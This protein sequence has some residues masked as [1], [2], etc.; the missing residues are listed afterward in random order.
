[1]LAAN[2]C[3]FRHQ[4]SQN[5]AHVAPAQLGHLHQQDVVVLNQTPQHSV[6]RDPHVL[7]SCSDAQARYLDLNVQGAGKTSSC[8]ATSG[9]CQ[10]TREES[11]HE[12]VLGQRVENTKIFGRLGGS[13]VSIYLRLTA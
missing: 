5:Q 8:P 13:A 9:C 2:S 11:R 7:P 12:T 6:W 10:E 3:L 1:M 4:I